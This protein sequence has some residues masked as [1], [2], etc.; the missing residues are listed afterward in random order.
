MT[1]DLKKH[2]DPDCKGNTKFILMAVITKQSTT[3]DEYLTFV[4]RN[5]ETEGGKVG[6]EWFKFSKGESSVS[7]WEEIQ[8][9]ASSPEI[10]MYRQNK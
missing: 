1:L 9:S 2:I 3:N 8:A 10:L 4:K 6:S 5:Y 7:S